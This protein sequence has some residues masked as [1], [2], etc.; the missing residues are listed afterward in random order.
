MAE[1]VSRRLPTA[2][3]EVQYS[4]LMKPATVPNSMCGAGTDFV[5]FIAQASI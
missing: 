5:L 2:Q 1:A 4:E 3:C